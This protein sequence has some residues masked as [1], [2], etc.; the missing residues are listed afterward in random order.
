MDRF[1]VPRE[2]GHESRG[3]EHPLDV[4]ETAATHTTRTR[5]I[6]RVAAAKLARRSPWGLESGTRWECGR[7]LMRAPRVPL[8]VSDRCGRREAL[9]S[10]EGCSR[11]EGSRDHPP[12]GKPADEDEAA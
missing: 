11:P 2:N 4:S 10:G 5:A 3:V 1:S 12:P 9:G 8:I 7:P 6:Y